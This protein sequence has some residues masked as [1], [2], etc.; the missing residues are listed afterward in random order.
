MTVVVDL[1]GNWLL[2]SFLEKSKS[3]VETGK[4]SELVLDHKTSILK[5]QKDQVKPKHGDQHSNLRWN[6]M[7]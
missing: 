5:Q 3:N 4:D 7:I 2:S 1:F 6:F